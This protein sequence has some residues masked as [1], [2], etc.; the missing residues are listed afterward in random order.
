MGEGREDWCVCTRGRVVS[1][2]GTRL[3]CL[4]EV[5]QNPLNFCR[6]I[7]KSSEH[8]QGQNAPQGLQN[9][10]GSLLEAE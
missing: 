8:Y 1:R 3:G 7:P 5:F 2:E 10:C 6:S 4:W 9:E